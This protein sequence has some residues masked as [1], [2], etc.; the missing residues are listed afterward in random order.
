[1]APIDTDERKLMSGQNVDGLYATRGE[2]ET[3][4]IG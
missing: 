2:W 3:V 4:R 1:M